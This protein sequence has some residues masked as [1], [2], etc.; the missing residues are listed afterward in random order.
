MTWV[1]VTS[2]LVL[3]SW[4]L[5]P[6]PSQ[7]SYDSTIA[8]FFCHNVVAAF[9]LAWNIVWYYFNYSDWKDFTKK[10]SLMI[11]IVINMQHLSTLWFK[12]GMDNNSANVMLRQL[13]GNAFG[14]L[15]RKTWLPNTF[16]QVIISYIF[17]WMGELY[18]ND[19]VYLLQT[20]NLLQIITIT[21]R[22]LAKGIA[23][24]NFMKSKMF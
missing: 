1:C 19:Q 4:G 2:L 13:A 22:N 5:P 6:N 12:D 8:I 16:Q 9:Y 14:H 24:L 20:I 7:L 18:Y 11:P 10:I 15:H 21:V 17:L 23:T 3:A